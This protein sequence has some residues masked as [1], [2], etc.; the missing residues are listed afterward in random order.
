MPIAHSQVQ[1]Y[2]LTSDLIIPLMA[3]SVPSSACRG[4]GYLSSDA[5]VLV[6]WAVYVPPRGPRRL[7][8]HRRSAVRCKRL[9]GVQQLMKP[10]TVASAMYLANTKVSLSLLIHLIAT[11]PLIDASDYF[12]DQWQRSRAPRAR[13]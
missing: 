11:Q 6:E 9:Q 13:E 12:L 7:S 2:W 10:G 8:A 5:N 3:R 4:S 1:I